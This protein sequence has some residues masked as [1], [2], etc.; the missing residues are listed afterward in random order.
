MNKRNL[1]A[2][3]AM[4][5]I[6][7]TNFMFPTGATAQVPSETQQLIDETDALLRDAGEFLQYTEQQRQQEMNALN[8]ACNNGDSNACTEYQLRINA[9]NRAIDNH[10]ETIRNRR[11]CGSPVCY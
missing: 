2:L 9:E 7:S 11:L 3:T 5:G 6:C 10:T 8:S 4:L 1:F